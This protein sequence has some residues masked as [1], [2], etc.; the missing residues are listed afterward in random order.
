MKKKQVIVIGGGESFAS[1]RAYL[2]F[3]KKREI[4]FEQYRRPR[5]GWKETLGTALG[6]R[7]EVIRIGMPNPLNAKY[8]EWKL[9]FEKFVPHLAR[10]T[11]FVGHSLGGVFLAKYL[12]KNRFSKRIRATFLVAAPF[13]WAD[14]SLPRNLARFARQ[15]GKIF[16]YQSADDAVVPPPDAEKYGKALPRAVARRFRRRGHFNQPSFPELARD[17]RASWARKRGPFRSRGGGRI[18]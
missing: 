12:S 15:G 7:F 1:H 3:L 16:I 10:E 8:A 18:I 4:D 5:R 14:F 13:G 17:L 2:S 11:A 9:W 6:S